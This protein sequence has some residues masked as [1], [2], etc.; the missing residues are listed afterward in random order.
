MTDHQKRLLPIHNHICCQ[1]T[2]CDGY[3][4]CIDKL[5]M[6]V[7]PATFKEFLDKSFMRYLD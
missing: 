6:K 2:Y 1:F 3:A 7:Y 4:V 5:C